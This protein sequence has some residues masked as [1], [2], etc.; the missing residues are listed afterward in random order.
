[1][2]DFNSLKTQNESQAAQINE[3]QAARDALKSEKDALQ[4]KLAKLK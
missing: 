3:V 4:T 1:M 2:A